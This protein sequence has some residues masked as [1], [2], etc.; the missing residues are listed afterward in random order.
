MPTVR[1]HPQ[2]Q[3]ST[4]AVLGIGVLAIAS[5]GPMIAYAAA[6]ALAIAFW[7]NGMAV[8]GL[9]PWALLRRPHARSAAEPRTGRRDGL[10]CLLSGVA[11]A[12]HFATWVPSAKLTS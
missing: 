6:P 12:A 2:V 9:A 3:P 1:A 7:R 8:G 10:L 5:S 11:L 4:V